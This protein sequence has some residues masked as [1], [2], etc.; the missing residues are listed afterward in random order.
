[1]NVLV[2]TSVWFSAFRKQGSSDQAAVA[3]LFLLLE[4]GENIAVT[5]TILQ[6]ILQGFRGAV[7]RRKVS[8]QLEAVPLLSLERSDFEAAAAIHRTCASKGIAA[9]T[10]DCQI[11]QAAIRHG[12]LL[13]TADRDFEHIA[14]HASLKLSASARHSTS[15]PFR[16]VHRSAIFS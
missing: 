11:A 16:I 2:D 7:A 9:S 12:H 8:E 6:E 14:K 3:K 1:M 4:E 15:V 13:L 10:V 5:G